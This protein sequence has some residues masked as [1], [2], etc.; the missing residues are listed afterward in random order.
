M[1]DNSIS[2]KKDSSKEFYILVTVGISILIVTFIVV[3]EMLVPVVK[4]EN[5]YIV[6]GVLKDSPV[7]HDPTRGPWFVSMKLRNYPQFNFEALYPSYGKQFITNNH[8][9]DSV[10]IGIFKDNLPNLLS[11]KPFYSLWA[12]LLGTENWKANVYYLEG[13]NTVYM[14]PDDYQ[15]RI[16]INMI[17]FGSIF[18][19]FGLL[20]IYGSVRALIKK[21]RS[22]SN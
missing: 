13:K 19:L 9:G 17:A 14:V 21:F 3:Y 2:E 11:G 22:R 20:C 4:S 7:Y 5:L 12:K 1:N 8:A 16:E 18:G 6:H 15:H 10:S